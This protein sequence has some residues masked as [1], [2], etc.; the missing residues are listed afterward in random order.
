LKQRCNALRHHSIAIS[1][2][3]VTNML[4]WADLLGGF[5]VK[6][7]HAE[8]QALEGLHESAERCEN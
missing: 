5:H 1:G 8:K 7:E 2:Q 6:E 3:L 4:R